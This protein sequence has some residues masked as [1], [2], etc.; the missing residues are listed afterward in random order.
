MK[1]RTFTLRGDICYSKTPDALQTVEDG[2]LVCVDGKSAGVFPRLPEEYRNL[3]MGDYRDRLIVPGLT[4][5]HMH[6][7]QF[8]FRGLGMDLELLEWLQTRAFPEEAKYGDRA[9]AKGS[10]AAMTEELKRGPNTRFCIFATLHVPA[11]LVLMDLLEQSGLVCMVGKVNMDRNSPNELREQNAER[12]VAATREWLDQ[13]GAYTNTYPILTPRFIPSCSD[14]LMT[15][16]AEIRREY[17]LPVQSHLSENRQELA[18]VRKLCPQSACYGGAYAAF[19]LFGAG[20][21]TVMAHC[22]WPEGN[23]ADLLRDRGVFVAH[24]PQ[25]NINLSSGIAP[26]RRYLDAGTVVGLGSD[27][28]GGVHSSIFRAMTDAIGVSKLRQALIDRDESPLSPEEVFY[29]GTRGG[30]SFFR[31]AGAGGPVGSFDAGYEFDALVIDDR[32]YA[33]P[34]PLAIRERLERTMYLSENRHIIAKY[35]RGAEIDRSST[36]V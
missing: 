28:A 4:D 3:P 20:A 9:Y 8:A 16:L 14:A 36:G 26:V 12:S 6:A 32:D 34:C 5:L 21:P 19:D 15:S 27:I 22:V 1:G 23:E 33:A 35:V 2:Y 10:Y 30:G 29:M 18:W 11:T 24:C 7:P 31:T 13:C 17:A 25:S